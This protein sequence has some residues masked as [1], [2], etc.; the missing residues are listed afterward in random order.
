MKKYW[1]VW[2]LIIIFILLGAVATVLALRFAWSGAEDRWV[3][4]EDMWIKH[5]NPPYNPPAGG[6]PRK[7]KD[8]N[9]KSENNMN[10]NKEQTNDQNKP[11]QNTQIANPASVYCTEHGGKLEIRDGQDGQ[12]GYCVFDDKSECEEWAFFRGECVPGVIFKKD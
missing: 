7:D 4:Q 1:W 3:C 10:N 11:G 2:L 6:C 8:N 12:T 9:Q 5:G